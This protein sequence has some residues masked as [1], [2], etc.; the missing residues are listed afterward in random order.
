MAV[1]DLQPLR[2]VDTDCA[3]RECARGWLREGFI[4]V[5]TEFIRTDTYYPIPA[6]IQIF[7]G[8]TNTLI[9]PV[10]ITQFEP[11]AEVLTHGAV[12][13]V[14]HSCS[15]D[16]EVFSRLL[17]VLP[18]PLLDTQIA[19][20][21]CGFGFTRGYATL[22]ELILGISLPKEETRSD[23]L[24]RP[25]TEAQG[26]YAVCDVEYLYRL[27]ARLLALLNE[28]ER[29]AWVQSECAALLSQAQ[30]MQT[31]DQ[32]YTKYKGAWRLAPR[33]LALLQRLAAWRETTAQQSD[34]PRNRIVDSKAVY[35]IAEKM[36]KHI[37]QLRTIETLRES[38][39]RRYGSRILEIVQEAV[40]LDQSKLPAVLARPPKGEDQKIM[41]KLRENVDL[42][43]ERMNIAPE[44][45]ANRRDLEILVT[46]SDD[47]PLPEHLQGWRAP[48]L[49]EALKATYE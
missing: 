23:W 31:P 45:I 47:T 1:T 14:F 25:L 20:A 3:L 37:S 29:L 39:I 35:S 19:A 21:F 12:T 40:A 2:W 22:V 49:D 10:N 34:I 38:S 5:D 18:A 15:E 48:F 26:Q 4:A 42:V 33:N 28:N 6:L 13:K 27:Y 44:V 32:A 43:A 41:K 46:M 9:D 7:D 36:P 24:Q 8:K 16:L 17:G 30:N 11:L